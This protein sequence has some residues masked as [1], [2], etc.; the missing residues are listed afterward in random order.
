MGSGSRTSLVP[1]Q[2]LR[3]RGTHTRR[4]AA[5]PRY[6]NES[7]SSAQIILTH[8]RQVALEAPSN[9]SRVGS[10][11]SRHRGSG[12]AP[13]IRVRSLRSS[14]Q[15]WVFVWTPSRFSNA[16]ASA[17]R[18]VLRVCFAVAAV[19]RSCAPRGVPWPRT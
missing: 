6:A 11:V 8:S 16:E 4:S 17:L 18:I 19:I 1:R 14:T 5:T 9:Q 2:E 13:D 7:R 15:R 10:G 3:A 12:R